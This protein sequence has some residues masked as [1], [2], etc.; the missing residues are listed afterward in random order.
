MGKKEKLKYGSKIH[1]ERRFKEHAIRKT[2]QHHVRGA[3]LRALLVPL[4]FLEV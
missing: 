1:F 4:K 3:M 2:H